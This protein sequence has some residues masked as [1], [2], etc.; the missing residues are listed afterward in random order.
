VVATVSSCTIWSN[1][2]V[3]VVELSTVNEHV[4]PWSEQTPFQL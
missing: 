2:A 3:T 4:D 1:V